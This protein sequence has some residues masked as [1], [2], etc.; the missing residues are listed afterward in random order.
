MPG[1]GDRLATKQDLRDFQQYLKDLLSQVQTFVDRGAT[2]EEAEAG[3][4]PPAYLDRTRLD[5]PSFKRLWA[6]SIRRAYAE[7]K[8]GPA[9]D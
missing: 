7:L 1:R 5:T 8:G 3:V 9:K 2:V 6:D 4:K